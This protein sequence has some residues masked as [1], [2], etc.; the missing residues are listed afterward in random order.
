MKSIAAELVDVGEKR[1]G[2]GRKI[3]SAQ[4]RQRL[5]AAYEASGLTQKV[6]CRREGV[7]YGTF[8]AWLGRHRRSRE[9]PSL[10]AS[11]PASFQELC[12]GGGARA[13]LEVRLPDGVMIR[14][15]SARELAELVRALRSLS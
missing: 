1:D 6:F 15:E 2:R 8:V 10:P 7:A 4:E 3:V 5:L 11:A 9:R 14:G 12:L 13:A